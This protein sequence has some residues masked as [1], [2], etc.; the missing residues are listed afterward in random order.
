MKLRLLKR[1]TTAGLIAATLFS[2]TGCLYLD[3][4]R[5]GSD[6]SARESVLTVQDAV[7]RYQEQTGLLP[8][9]NSAE[10]VPLY[11]KFKIDFGKLKRM[12]M[13]AQVPSAAFENG[14]SYQF[15]IIDE[16]SKPLVKLLDLV[17]FQLVA[18]IQKKVDEYGGQH[19]NK[20]PVGVE[21]Y[22]GFRSVDFNKLGSKAPEIVSD[23]SHQFL[24]LIADE[25][26]KVY[27]DY[28]I[29]IASALNKA[30]TTPSAD[31]DL[32]RALIDAS[33]YVPVRAPVYHWANGAPQAVLAE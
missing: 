29:D 10:S 14:G 31:V 33:Y 20:L 17:Q 27:I 11:E 19:G 26:G 24:N 16:D 15:L 7:D 28:G 22:P 8:L 9:L 18:D 1:V 12:N 5:V 32:R 2:L 13:I 25:Q 23:Y 6:V 3:D 21:V 4:Q 30:G